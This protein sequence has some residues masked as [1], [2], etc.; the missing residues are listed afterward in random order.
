MRTP[1]AGA[2]IFPTSGISSRGVS[3]A[4]SRGASSKPR[5]VHT[6]THR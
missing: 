3:A 2:R 6:P 1:M 4:T 5:T